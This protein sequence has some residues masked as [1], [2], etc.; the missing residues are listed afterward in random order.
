MV[1]VR[2]KPILFKLMTFEIL[3]GKIQKKVNNHVHI[4]IDLY[5]WIFT[6]FRRF[7]S[8]LF[9]FFGVEFGHRM[10]PPFSK[11]AVKV[12]TRKTFLILL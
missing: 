5:F 12:A 2:N 8:F 7:W 3:R 10:L 9:I 4:D 11:S 1:Q 6:N